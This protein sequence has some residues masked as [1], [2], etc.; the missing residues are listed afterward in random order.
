MLK[1]KRIQFVK[2]AENRVNRTLK[3]IDL[4]GNLS[5]ENNYSYTDSDVAKMCAALEAALKEMKERFET[6][7]KYKMTEFKLEEYEE[8]DDEN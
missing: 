3:N 6:V 7:S 4:I 5:D 1:R 8:D 2:L